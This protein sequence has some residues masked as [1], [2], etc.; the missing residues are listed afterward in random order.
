MSDSVTKY[1]ENVDTTIPVKQK[2]FN[3]A[4]RYR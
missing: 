4:G 2:G 3:C 1:F